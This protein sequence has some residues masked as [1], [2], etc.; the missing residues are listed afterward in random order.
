VR[1]YYVVMELSDDEWAGEAGDLATWIE[2]AMNRIDGDPNDIDATVY[3]NLE[4]FIADNVLD[5]LASVP[6]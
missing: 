6:E 4:D 2:A 1:K 3:D 5:A